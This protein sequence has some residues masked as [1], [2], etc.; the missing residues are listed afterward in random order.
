[1]QA[2]GPYPAL[3]AHPAARPVSQLILGKPVEEAAALLP[4]LFNLCRTAQ[5]IAARAAFG[6]APQ[7]DWQ[8]ALRAEILREH[9]VKL[10]LKWPAAVSRAAVPLPRDWMA[11]SD[12][13][14]VAL[15]GPAGQLPDTASG[16][17]AFLNQQDGI[18]PLLRAISQLF[19]PGQG[20]RATLSLATPDT[21]FAV[22]ALENSVAARRHVHPVMQAVAQRWGRGPLWSV[23]GVAY[24]LEAIFDGDMPPAMLA[25]GCAVVPAA[26]GLYAV[27]ARVEKGCVVAFTRITP[28]DH[29]LAVGGALEQ[30]LAALPADTADATA[31]LVLS[32]LDPCFPVSLQPD[33]RK[34]PAH[35]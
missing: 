24:D 32:I 12:A 21:V 34:E 20:C 30:A 29:L 6:L 31:P 7:P 10:C 23:L 3:R 26:R 13:A 22:G 11:G 27:R 1:M 14:R 35:A 4:R 17:D 28:T 18:A 25:T 9:I 33:P 5:A 15:F 19:A 16:L 2:R 8:S